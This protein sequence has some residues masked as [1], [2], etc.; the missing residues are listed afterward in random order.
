MNL[1]DAIAQAVTRLY[2]SSDP[3]DLEAADELANHPTGGKP[4]EEGGVSERDARILALAHEWEDVD[5]IELDQETKISEGED[6][7]AWV[8][9]WVWVD[10]A[11][12]DLDKEGG[13]IV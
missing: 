5:E 12:T 10:F 4:T 6:N 1:S 13:M 2:D 8:R 11:G 3:V 9:A 7:G